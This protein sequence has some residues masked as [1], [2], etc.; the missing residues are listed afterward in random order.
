MSNPTIRTLIAECEV[1]YYKIVP[2][3]RHIN[4]ALADSTMKFWHSLPPVQV[5][6]GEMTRLKRLAMSLEANNTKSIT[7]TTTTDRSQPKRRT[8]K[9]TIGTAGLNSYT[10]KTNDNH[11]K[12]LEIVEQAWESK[13]QHKLAVERE[14]AWHRNNNQRMSFEANKR[15]TEKEKER[16]KARRRCETARVDLARKLPKKQQ[17]AAMKEKHHQLQVL[18]LRETQRQQAQQLNEQKEQDHEQM[19]QQQECLQLQ[20][21]EQE[22]QRVIEQQ[23]ISDNRKKVSAAQRD[24]GKQKKKVQYVSIGTSDVQR[25]RSKD[26]GK[27][28]ME[29]GMQMIADRFG[30]G[31]HKSIGKSFGVQRIAALFGDG[32]T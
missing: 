13:R 16:E 1:A 19:K 14:Q 31:W 3:T 21:Q 2:H 6:L 23:Q 22:Q 10:I 24:K 27:Y 28:G 5:I 32:V 20:Q 18:K 30:D 29:F 25:Q 15:E 12:A 8:N 17:Q 11:T 26:P 7:T 4:P 9:D